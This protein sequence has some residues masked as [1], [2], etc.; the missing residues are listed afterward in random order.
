M[1]FLCAFLAFPGQGK[2]AE[3]GCPAMDNG[4]G[5]QLSQEQIN[6]AREI[7]NRNFANMDSTRQTLNAKRAELDSLLASPNPDSARIEE[8]SRDIGQLRGKMLAARAGVRSELAKK[9]LSPD[10]LS[11]APQGNWEQQYV[12]PQPYHHGHP[13]HRGH[14][15]GRGYGCGGCW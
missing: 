8:L 11:P 9:G 1:L 6:A 14:G 5:N 3:W 12:G 2:A 4:Y 15:Y 13:R 7:I 10:F